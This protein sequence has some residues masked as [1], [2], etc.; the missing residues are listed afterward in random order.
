MAREAIDQGGS[1]S[2]AFVA[3]ATLRTM[4]VINVLIHE[5][6][7]DDST[8]R[9]VHMSAVLLRFKGMRISYLQKGYLFVKR[10]AMS[11]DDAP[12]QHA[13]FA[14]HILLVVPRYFLPTNH[15]SE[16]LAVR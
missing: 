7:E 14:D 4:I 11:A 16:L 2:S 8:L 9:Y 6:R 15:N 5:S 13:S 12:W 1:A 3:S 10:P